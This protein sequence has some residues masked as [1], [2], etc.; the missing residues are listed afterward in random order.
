MNAGWSVELSSKE[1]NRKF[2]ATL[3]FPGVKIAGTGI[4]RPSQQFEKKTAGNPM[5]KAYGSQLQSISAKGFLSEQ[6][7]LQLNDHKGIDIAVGADSTQF[8]VYEIAIPIKELMPESSVQ[9]DELITLNVSVNALDRAT[10][11]G[12]RSGRGGSMSERGGVRQGGGMGGRSGGRMGGGRQD[13]GMN[14]ERGTSENGY[15]E[16]FGLSE[17]VSFKQ[18][19]TLAK[20]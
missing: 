15:G 5:I 6:V 17:K 8:I 3:A 14:Q 13:G 10:S 11:G 18:K 2:N 16:K 12:G 1:K 4:R 20:N 7:T 19:F 9:L